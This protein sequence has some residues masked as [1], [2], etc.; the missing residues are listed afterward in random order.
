MKG[1][2]TSQPTRNKIS[3][4]A[5]L[6]LKKRKN[7]KTAHLNLRKVKILKVFGKEQRIVKEQYVKKDCILIVGGRG[8]GKTR[9]LKKL[10]E[11]A[12]L[13]WET[14]AYLINAKRVKEK[15][16]IDPEKV[17]LIDD[18][19]TLDKVNDRP[20]INK[21]KEIIRKARAVVL[22]AE[23]TK[24]IDSGLLS[25]IRR[26]QKKKK[27]ETIEITDLGGTEEEIKDI[28]VILII[29][30]MLGAGLIYGMTDAFIL[31]LLLRYLTI[32]SRWID[33]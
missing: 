10:H 14:E 22:T 30:L 1:D 19:D 12:I 11:N 28:G 7:R 2:L 8:T 26:R 29:F 31:G 3:P 23:N 4:M 33:K 24:N 17:Y 16:K 13:I 21:I 9:E 27:W 25:E 20:K 18:I 6:V 15:E 32:E 5:Y